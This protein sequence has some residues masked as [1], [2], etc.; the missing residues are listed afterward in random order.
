MIVLIIAFSIATRWPALNARC[1]VAWRDSDCPRGSSR[2]AWRRVGRVLDEGRGD[3]MI[4]R[5][6]GAITM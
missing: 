1:L 6:I 5:R 4:D 3:R 2:S